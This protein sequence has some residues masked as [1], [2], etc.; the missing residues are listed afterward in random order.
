M[1]HLHLFKESLGWLAMVAFAA[2]YL[3]KNAV[4]LRRA[5]AGAAVVWIIYG[6][7]SGTAPVV[8]SN[9]VVA[10]MAVA[11]PAIKQRLEQPSVKPA[12]P[13][14]DPASPPAKRLVLPRHYIPMAQPFGW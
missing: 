9:A 3:C 10:F 13:L 8:V 1:N 14:I 5:Q 4:T 2:S 6:L 12:P 11:Y 7:A